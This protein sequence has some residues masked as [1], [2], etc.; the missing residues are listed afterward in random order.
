MSVA[1]T[2]AVREGLL[3]RVFSR[4]HVGPCEVSH[5]FIISLSFSWGFMES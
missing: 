1:P 4:F 5:D 2:E 3:Q